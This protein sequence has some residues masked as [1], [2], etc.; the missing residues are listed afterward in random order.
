MSHHQCT[1]NSQPQ[2]EPAKTVR[3]RGSTLFKCV[4]NLGQY[5]LFN[6]DP[7]VAYLNLQF[8]GHGI[9]GFNAHF[10]LIR[11]EFD[12]VLEQIPKNLLEAGR[13]GGNRVFAGVEMKRKP[14]LFARNVF[15]TSVECVTQNLMRIGGAKRVR[16]RRSSIRRA[17][18][19]TL[20]RIV[21]KSSS[22]SEVL[23]VLT[24]TEETAV[25]I[26]VSGVRNSWER[27]ARN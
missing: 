8:T 24:W 27:A 5:C 20:R 21:V 19:S 9:A 15:Q 26:G 25:R 23:S 7:G 13:I 11:G 16:S 10:A 22:N 2:T 18:S 4:K 6:P 17:S 14:Q 3:H 1:G 12:R